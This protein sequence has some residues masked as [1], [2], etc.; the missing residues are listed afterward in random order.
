V[1]Q[2]AGPPAPETL[3]R[4][5]ADR[6][7]RIVR[8]A[9]RSLAD[10]EF[11]RI[12][13]S[14]VARDSG[15]A[16]GTV[17]RY[18]VSKDHLFAAVY[19]EWQGALKDKMERAAPSGSR[20]QDRVK[21]VM[22]RVIRAFQQ[23]PQFLTLL[24]VLRATDDAYA[25]EILGSLGSLHMEIVDPLFDRAPQSDRAAIV[26]TVESVMMNYLQSW[27]TNRT[28][29]ENVYSAVDDAIRLIYDFP[30]KR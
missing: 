21:D 15:V 12:K 1:V 14:D 16:L 8:T 30:P 22:H 20:E 26:N 5:Q 3:R 17:Y 13:I 18:F 7:K 6:R 2:V 10:D 4:D 19:A 25:K 24:M 9:L 23:Q 27:V 11:D 29:I 28:A